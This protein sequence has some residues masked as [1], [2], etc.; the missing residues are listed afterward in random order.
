[1]YGMSLF[2]DQ[3]DYYYDPDY[4]SDGSGYEDSE[5]IAQQARL[6]QAPDAQLAATYAPAFIPPANNRSQSPVQVEWEDLVSDEKLTAEEVMSCLGGLQHVLVM[7]PKA[8]LPALEDT[9]S[10]RRLF[11]LLPS[12]SPNVNDLIELAHDV[13]TR[14]SIY[15]VA[16][17]PLLADYVAEGPGER[18]IYIP[19]AGSTSP[20]IGGGAPH[21]LLGNMSFEL[22]RYWSSGD[23]RV[24]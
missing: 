22:W 24:R 9:E 6:A 2:H 18:R 17:W 23:F 21:D 13:L 10:W 3:N 19:K 11:I 20:L 5:L 12:S 1:M 16:L 7:E 15:N 14:T 4:L 8:Q